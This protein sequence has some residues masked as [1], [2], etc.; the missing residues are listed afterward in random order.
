MRKKLG[1]ELRQLIIWATAITLSLFLL[2]VAYFMIDVAVT[3][4]NNIDENKQL[5]IDESVSTMQDMADS[6]NSMSDNS[7]LIGYLNYDDIAVDVMHGNTQ[8]ML[9]MMIDL[10][11]AFYPIEYDGVWQNGKVLA[12]GTVDGSTIDTS[13]LPDKPAEGSYVTFDN[14]GGREG[15]FISLYMPIKTPVIGN[16]ETNFI[17][18]RTED[19]KQIESYFNDQR[20]SLLTRMAI[21][22]IIAFIL[23]ALFSTMGL[24]FLVGKFVMGPIDKLNSQAEGIIS[25]S[26]DE[27][28]PYDKD[29]SFAA[30]QGVLRSGKMV[31]MDMNKEIGD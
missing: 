16:M 2:V 7:T 11:L 3:T 5:V 30:I 29:S 25:G 23:F 20:N 24:R 31:L 28:I 14:F 6:I 22:S 18:D 15:F 19:V 27:E 10:A 4:S 8:S 12:Y 21:V 17:M 9:K 26:L 1:K 13:A